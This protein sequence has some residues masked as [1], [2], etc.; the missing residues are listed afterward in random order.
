MRRDTSVGLAV[1]LGCF[2]LSA[3]VNVAWGV[4]DIGDNRCREET[5]TAASQRCA[6]GGVG[7]PPPCSWCEADSGGVKK[8]CG[9]TPGTCHGIDGNPTYCGHPHTGALCYN[10]VCSGG[11]LDPNSTC[12]QRECTGD[13]P[14][15]P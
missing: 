3:L 11:V 12:S 9:W 1:V 8:Y 13:S 7:N 10:K 6:Y 14:P 2:V 5:C 15:T 4:V